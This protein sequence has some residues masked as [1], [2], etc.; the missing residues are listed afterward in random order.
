MS[1]AAILPSM[2]TTERRFGAQSMSS[3]LLDVLV[4]RPGPAFGAAFDDP[5]HGFLH[6]VDLDLAQR[7]HDAFVE[8]LASLGPR[9]HVLE[10]ELDDAGPRLH[11]RSAA[12]D[13]PRR[14]PAP[15]GQ[16]EPG[17][18][19]GRHRGVDD[20][21]RHPDPRADRGARDDRG[22]RHVL[23]AAGPVLHRAD[24]A[25]QRRRGRASWPTSSAAT[26]ASSTS[27]TGAARPS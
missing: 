2:M 12:G 4:K 27:R 14:D 9:V 19:T 22:R 11:L 26:S 21:G 24:V 15:A 10:T 17:P 6:P 20:R 25:H 1:G 8:T 16:A 5:A 18:G 3:P 23:A 13:R 7:Q